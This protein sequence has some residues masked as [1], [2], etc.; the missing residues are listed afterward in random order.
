LNTSVTD[1]NLGYNK[2]GDEGVAALA[3]GLK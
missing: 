2:I 1:T 3:K